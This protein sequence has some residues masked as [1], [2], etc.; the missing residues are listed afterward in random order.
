M[1]TQMSDK[2]LKNIFHHTKVDIENN[3]F[4]D[5]VM[6]Q[7]PKTS[8]RYTYIICISFFIGILMFVLTSGYQMFQKL[9]FS[10]ADSLIN[11]QLPSIEA[12]AVCLAGVFIIFLIINVVSEES[13]SQI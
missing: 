7:L 1:N 11:L 13:V 4:S 5:I 8:G 9:Y 3:G 10:F 2:E 6:Q 12:V